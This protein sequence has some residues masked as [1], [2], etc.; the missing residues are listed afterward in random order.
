MFQFMMLWTISNDFFLLIPH[1]PALSGC[2]STSAFTFHGKHAFFK[3]FIRIQSYY[4]DEMSWLRPSYHNGIHCWYMHWCNLHTLWQNQKTEQGYSSDKLPPTYDTYMN[5]LKKVNDQIYI[6]M[7][8]C[9]L[10]NIHN[11]PQPNGNLAT[12]ANFQHC[13]V[14]AKTRI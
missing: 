10:I 7:Q 1:I 8:W 2:D 3:S 4:R 6:W 11:I 5:H 14:L 12:H 13:I 9:M